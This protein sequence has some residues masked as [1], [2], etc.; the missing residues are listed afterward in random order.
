MRNYCTIIGVILLLFYNIIVCRSQQRTDSISNIIMKESMDTE[1]LS[2]TVDDIELPLYPAYRDYF[3]QVGTF[4]YSFLR[5]QERGY[6]SRYSEQRWCGLQYNDYWSGLPFW[7]AT[8]GLS[9][10]PNYQTNLRGLSYD[11]LATGIGTL[12]GV[13]AIFNEESYDQRIKGAYSFSNRTYTNRATAQYSSGRLAHGWNVTAELSRRWGRS[14]SIEGVFADSW[15]ALATV[16]K[17]F[18]DKHSVELT[19]FFAPTERG[20]QSPSTQEA[21]E[22]TGNNLYN[23]NWGYQNDLKRTNRIRSTMMPIAILSHTWRISPQSRLF[24]SVGAS[25]GT[26][27]YSALNWQNAP[28]PYP[29]YYRY[30]PSYEKSPQAQALL[31]TLWQTDP[32]VNQI[33]Y[34]GIYD[35]NRAHSPTAYIV[36]NRVRQIST[37]SAQSTLNMMLGPTAFSAGVELYYS[38][39]NRYKTVKDLLGGDYWLDIDYFTESDDDFRMMTQNNMAS[40]NAHAT[41]GDRFGYNF[42]LR[43]LSSSVWVSAEHRMSNWYFSGAASVSYSALQRY[44]HW[45]KQLYPGAQSLG[46]SPWLQN[47]EYMAKLSAE[48]RL[49]KKLS[50]KIALMAQNRA[51]TPQNSL[52]NPEYRNAFSPNLQ[53]E[54]IFSAEMS[55]SYVTENI[56]AGASLY[57]TSIA[58][59]TELNHLYDDRFGLYTDFLLQD[60][61]AEYMGVELNGEF[62]LFDDLWLRVAAALSDNRYTKNPTASIYDQTTGALLSTEAIFYQGLHTPLSPQT[63]GSI[64][65][66]YQPRGWI[67]SLTANVFARSFIAPSPTHYTQGAMNSATNA[68]IMSTQ[69]QFPTG[70]TID[71]F[72]GKTF[73]FNNYSRLGIYA[74]L[75]NITDRRT[76]KT[77]GYQSNRLFREAGRYSPQPSKYY[78]ALGFNGF[79]NIS[80][81]F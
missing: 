65:F 77:A 59:Q 18:S 44:G 19:L 47:I 17:S 27:N 79:I 24:S 38:W 80:Y 76:I 50:A 40:P 31:T 46:A 25:T 22:L 42:R 8:T 43:H 23:P 57:W 71:V 52:L 61:A 7:S 73:T 36:E 45:E 74:G 64:S 69:E 70:M 56:R 10:M 20:T 12:G 29:D 11:P 39:E 37:L 5:F 33:N 6:H 58:N 53:N 66:A 68:A 9:S 2:P 81:S 26:S 55:F 3:S 49:G 14:L 62:R 32:S 28:N 4:G 72:G 60:I 48:Y 78:Y 63:I 67:V 16:G 34:A 54:Q 21:F 51:P 1:A 75:N 41:I 13:N 15:T 30:M 35:F